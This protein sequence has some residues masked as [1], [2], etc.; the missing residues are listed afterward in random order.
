MQYV[1]IGQ[2]CNRAAR[3]AQEYGSAH[4]AQSLHHP[5][6][7]ELHAAMLRIHSVQWDNV[8]ISPSVICAVVNRSL[9]GGAIS[10][11]SDNGALLSNRSSFTNNTAGEQFEQPLNLA[12]L[13]G[14][15]SV[16]SE[17]GALLVQGNDITL[18]VVDTNM[19]GNQ[20][21]RVSLLRL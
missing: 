6:L 3:P 15:R 18:T 8:S 7:L 16:Q 17:G 13:A 2:G 4:A 9:Q 10:L 20:A 19:T 21:G 5:R 11:N 12:H 14:S 1:C